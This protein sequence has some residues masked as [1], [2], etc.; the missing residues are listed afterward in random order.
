MDFGERVAFAPAIGVRTRSLV[1]ELRKY[2]G[3]VVTAKKLTSLCL[4][5][6]G[7]ITFLLTGCTKNTPT[8]ENTKAATN[9]FSFA[10]YG[11]SRTM[12]YLPYRAA[13]KADA[14]NY[15]VDMFKLVFPEKIA[16]E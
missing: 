9:E 4:V 12:M 15:M 14:T 7:A 1:N 8:G 13:D 10:V 11:D 16:K 3:G 2:S 6:V 5:Y